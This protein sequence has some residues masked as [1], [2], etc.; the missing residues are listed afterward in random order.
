MRIRTIKPEFWTHQV[1]GR[2]S[3]RA[4]LVAIG[5]HNL[6][7]DE[8]YFQ[9]EP[10]LI[11]NQ[12]FPLQDDYGTT[13]VSL[14]ELHGAG[15]ISIKST[16]ESGPIGL[17]VNFVTHQVINKP[18][19]SKIKQY[20]DVGLVPDEYGTST[21]LLPSGR[22]GK[23]R[24]RNIIGAACAD[25]EN[26]QKPK[27]KIP[28]TDFHQTLE[29]ICVAYLEETGSKYLVSGAKDTSALKELLNNF[30][31]EEILARWRT[32]LKTQG[33]Y[34]TSSIAEFNSLTPQK[35]TEKRDSL[36]GYV[37]A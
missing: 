10:R 5:L 37:R 32:G 28:E 2:L 29:A 34:R 14:Q 36:G 30:K 33:F 35:P 13:T 4:K 18:K 12:L 3:D 19:G 8:G 15:F 21:V 1:L 26:L 6:A 20:H 11:H 27:R 9:A 24:E 22:E 31:P 16:P 25:G 17:V 23:G 7:D